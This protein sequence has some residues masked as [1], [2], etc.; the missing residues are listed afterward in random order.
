MPGKR[1]CDVL[2]D[3]RKIN[4]NVK[5]I[6]MSG[7]SMDFVPKN[8]LIGEG[9]SF[10]SKPLVVPNLLRKVREALDL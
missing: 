5:V 9:C 8:H 1:G 2:V 3:I 6:F 7:Y 10:I 4:P